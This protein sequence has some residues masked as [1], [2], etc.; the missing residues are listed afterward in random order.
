M[1]PVLL[2]IFLLLTA[3]SPLKA[4]RYTST[5]NRDTINYTDKQGLRQGLWQITVPGLR[6]ERGYI[7]E[8]R[9]VNN[10]KEGIWKKYSISGDPIAIETYKDSVLDG[11]AMYFYENG[12]IKTDGSYRAVVKENSARAINVI[13]PLTGKDTTVTVYEYAHSVKKGTWKFYTPDGNLETTVIYDND[14]PPSTAAA[15]LPP[16][17]SQPEK[18][19][20][21][22]AVQQYE[23][24]TKKK[25][26]GS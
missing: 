18:D 5:G 12:G 20:S 9:Y 4:Q 8:G 25:K 19:S 10:K 21:P 13:N 3:V 1:R 15:P 26:H 17:T 16:T 7:E 24:K 6:G 23:K 11:R 14:Q 22:P 2:F